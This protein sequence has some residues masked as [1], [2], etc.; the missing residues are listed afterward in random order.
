MAPLPRRTGRRSRTGP[1]GAESR[2]SACR[3]ARCAT[4]RTW[5][6]LAVWAS[7]GRWSLLDQRGTGRSAVPVD[8]S[9]YRGDRLVADV[10]A[11]RRHLGLHRMD[12]LGHSAGAERGTAVRGRH[13][14]ALGRPRAGHAE[15]PGGRAARRPPR[16]ARRSP[17]P[18]RPSRGFRQR[19]R[20]WI[21]WWLVGPARKP[22]RRSPRSSTAGGTRRP[23]HTRRPSRPAQR[24]GG[25][26]LRQRGRLRPA[27][28]RAALAAHRGAVLLLAG[29]STSARRPASWPS[30]A[31]RS[32]RGLV[33]QMGVVTIRGSTTPRRSAPRCGVPH[34]PGGCLSL[35]RG[36]AEGWG[37]E[38]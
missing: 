19:P 35:H 21:P 14:T 4:P 33:V 16:C 25:A 10:E 34:R 38:R 22:G 20:L 36:E 18:A 5:V 11:L 23:R 2:W 15:H 3:A 30:S 28:T 24:G 13:P 37:H 26:G 8:A 1:S 27:A 32:R 31:R 7:T 12:L 17:G 9:S 29:E 6:T